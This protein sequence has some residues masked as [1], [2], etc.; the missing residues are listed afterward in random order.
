MNELQKWL[1]RNPVTPDQRGYLSDGGITNCMVRLPNGTS[2]DV[3]FPRVPCEGEAIE[4]YLADG[5][6][7]CRVKLVYWVEREGEATALIVLEKE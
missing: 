4:V 1:E 5:P 3:W 7:V 2:K 6:L